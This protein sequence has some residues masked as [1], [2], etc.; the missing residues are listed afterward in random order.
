MIGLFSGQA[1]WAEENQD[2]DNT[3]AAGIVFK[4]TYVFGAHGTWSDLEHNSPEA[5]KRTMATISKDLSSFSDSE[6]GRKLKSRGESLI[7]FLVRGV[8][9]TANAGDPD[10]EKFLKELGLDPKSAD[11]VKLAQIFFE[12]IAAYAEISKTPSW[13]YDPTKRE[14]ANPAQQPKTSESKD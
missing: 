3:V 5:F 1:L 9:S 6:H 8:T 12:R 13:V 10:G 11:P 14:Q 7:S 2:I 4:I